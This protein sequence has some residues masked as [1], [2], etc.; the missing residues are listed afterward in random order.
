MI[1][2]VLRYLTK[3]KLKCLFSDGGIF[4]SAASEQ[5]DNQEGIYDHKI[6]SK[7]I[8]KY[9]HINLN[10]NTEE[11][12]NN[13]SYDLMMSARNIHFLNSWY[14]TDNEQIEM[15]NRYATD[16][17]IIVSNTLSLLIHTPDPLGHAMARFPVIYNDVLKKV[18]VNK[19]LA[20]KNSHFKD[21][22]EYRLT[23]DLLTYSI[24]TGFEKEMCGIT[25]V[26]KTPSYE[27][28]EIL[29]TLSEHGKKN[30]LKV[31]TRKNFGYI[32]KFNLAEIIQEIRVHPNS[33][34]SQLEDI[35][36]I[37]KNNGLNIPVKKSLLASQP[38]RV[39]K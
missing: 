37:C 19:P 8:K 2:Q 30:A 15:W 10:V 20:V 39:G 1:S 33:T 38:G 29:Q 4:F 32:L 5:S 18:A 36:L 26:G 6:I 12:I 34:Q 16:G 25:Y 3:Q 23:F 27:S 9:P 22:N 11:N 24:I 14:L 35:Q 13:I 21:E 28:E 7:S 31:I 17:V